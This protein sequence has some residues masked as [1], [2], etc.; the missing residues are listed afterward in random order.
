MEFDPPVNKRTTEQL[1]DIIE[2]QEQ[3]KAD[4]VEMAQIEL[5]KRGVSINKQQKRRKSKINYIRRIVFIKANAT[6]ST[7]EKI[8]IVLLGPVLA[9]LLDDLLMFHP[10]EGYKQ[11]NRQG[12]L[13]FSLGIGLWGL[14][15]YVY[16]LKFA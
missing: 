11:K 8:L 7:T 5:V 4:V 3:W 15:L 13:Y 14:I 12:F 6:Y 2:T 1:L 9:I 10:G 16:L